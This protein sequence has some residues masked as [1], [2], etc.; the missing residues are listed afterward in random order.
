MDFPRPSVS[1]SHLIG[2]L[3]DRFGFGNNQRRRDEDAYYD[4]Y[5][6]YAPEE[7]GYYDTAP[8]Y[9]N[10]RQADPYD[11][12]EYTTRTAAG[13]GSARGAYT[14]PHL[15]NTDDIRATTSAYG[16]NTAA[17]STASTYGSSYASSSY[18]A[19][20]GT[21]SY[22]AGSS[23]NSYTS[24]SSSLSSLHPADKLDEEA[25][26]YTDFVSPYQSASASRTTQGSSGLDSLF[27]PSSSTSAAGSATF[28]GS[29]LRGG[30]AAGNTAASKST[31]SGS[32]SSYAQLNESLLTP[33]SSTTTSAAQTSVLGAGT[34]SAQGSGS[35]AA[36]KNNTPTSLVGG[37]AGTSS[38]REITLL[39]PITYE[40]VATVARSVRA[41]N[42][43]V[44]SLRSTD[45]ALAKRILDFSF[46]VASAL[47][48]RVDCV[49]DKT[50][51]IVQG[52]DLSLE[53]RHRLQKQ[54]IL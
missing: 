42:I 22:S 54:G 45:N 7:D 34:T 12:L 35:N 36:S 40:D 23:S 31:Y 8:T 38:S 5:D 41:G 27:Q 24:S 17:G 53:E 1:P 47:D 6:D 4:D 43:V 11:R 25:T 39:Q 46:G 26:S 2:D 50:F 49:A 3:K 14:S 29:N 10:D 32:A 13:R 9:Q 28:A 16:V 37:T 30:A 33:E 48:V 44:L 21:G 18:S 15:I 52:S 51:V 20:S 19:G